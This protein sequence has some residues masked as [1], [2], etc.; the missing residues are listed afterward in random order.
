MDEPETRVFEASEEPEEPEEPNFYWRVPHGLVL[1]LGAAAIGAAAGFFV[2]GDV[3]IGSVLLTVSVF[4]LL[5][6]T[7]EAARRRA[8]FLDGVV[9]SGYDRVRALSGYAGASLRTWG[10][11][12]GRVTRLRLKM[13]TLARERRQAQ[14]ELGGAAY[15]GN[16]SA[17]DALIERMRTLDEQLAECTAEMAR[18]VEEAQ[19]HLAEERLAIKPTEI[20]RAAH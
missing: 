17:V 20:R 8:S 12:S 16:T 4:A 6:F 7:Q 10:R 15:A 2:R 5:I 13:H 18:A 14:F 19:S 1:V 9:A 11:T 3:V